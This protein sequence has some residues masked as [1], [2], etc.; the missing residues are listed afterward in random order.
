MLFYLKKDEYNYNH[1]WQYYFY[2][3]AYFPKL[4]KEV[5]RKI[6]C[7]LDPNYNNSVRL[8][9]VCLPMVS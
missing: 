8:Y 3:Y 9:I 4:S 5:R 1:F 6:C 7:G 2:L